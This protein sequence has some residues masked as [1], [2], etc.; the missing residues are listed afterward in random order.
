MRPWRT[1]WLLATSLLLGPSAALAADS[2]VAFTDAERARIVGLGPWPP[3]IARDPS[4]RVSGQARAI[5]LGRRLFFD[6]RMSPVGY[7]A[8]VS[9]HAPDRAFADL[10]P[11]AH[12]LADLERN[13]IALANLRLQRWYGWGGSSDS[14]W[15]A[16]LRPILDSREFDGS[17]AS[18]TRLFRRDEEL[19]RCYR[20]VFGLPPTG[21]EERILVN[22]GKALAA[23]LETLQTGRTPFDDLRDA[24]A[25]SD[26]VPSGYSIPA[27]RGLRLFVGR[28]GCVDCHRGPNFSDG[29]FHATGAPPLIAPSPPDRGRADGARLLVASRY[30]LAGPFSD[31]PRRPATSVDIN[32]SPGDAGF[33]TPSLRNVAV[34]APYMHNGRVESLADAIRQHAVGHTLGALSSDGDVA[35]LVAFLQTLTDA[36]GERRHVPPSQT[37]CPP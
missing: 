6:P 27:Q 9:C 22:V 12:G 21:D 25:R 2:A 34:T 1:G 3:A 37:A 13:T 31:A 10:K 11:R 28:A 5:D 35:D 17:A 23:F 26:A 33:R 4:N 29:A 14:L 8:C 15:L 19:A 32:K 24:L 36:D 20:T 16:S 7:V 18:V 30:N